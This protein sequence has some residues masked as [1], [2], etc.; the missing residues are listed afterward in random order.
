[1]SM[2]PHDPHAAG[3][4]AIER[5]L[6]ALC[7]AT[8]PADDEPTCNLWYIRRQLGRFEYGDRRMVSYVTRLIEQAAF[9]PPL[10]TL[11]TRSAELITAVTP[12]SRWLR[13]AV[14]AWLA[15]FL[16]PA[17]QVAVDRAAQAAAAA[18]MDHAAGQLTLIR[19][20]RA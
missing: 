3:R 19:G 9:P 14:D 17:A 13:V 11:S 18:A 15:D 10:P 1:M 20:G 12:H 4:A 2:L 8:V 7:P 5:Q 6:D 16:P